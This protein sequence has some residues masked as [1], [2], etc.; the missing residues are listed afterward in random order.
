[1]ALNVNRII[2]FLI[3]AEK[4]T[5]YLENN[6]IAALYFIFLCTYSFSISCCKGD[7][8]YGTSEAN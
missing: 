4:V 3:I 2:S 7:E 8:H 6:L 5:F 1:M